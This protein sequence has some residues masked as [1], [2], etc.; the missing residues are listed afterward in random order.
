MKLFNA[1][2]AAA[3]ISASFISTAPA[4]AFWEHITRRYSSKAEAEEACRDF[5]IFNGSIKVIEGSRVKK[6]DN[7]FCKDDPSTRQILG[8]QYMEISKI[9]TSRNYPLSVTYRPKVKWRYYY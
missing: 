3:V 9:N 7:G 1:I 2:A 6:L 4:E 8:Y 5:S